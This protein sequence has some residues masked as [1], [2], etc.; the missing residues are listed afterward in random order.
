MRPT[1]RTSSRPRPAPTGRTASTRSSPTSGTAPRATTASPT[2]APAPRRATGPAASPCETC[3]CRGQSSMA[4][5]P[6]C[7]ARRPYRRPHRR[8]LHRR[9]HR[10]RPLRLRG[11]AAPV[12]GGRAAPVRGP[13]ATRTIP[14]VQ[15]ARS[16]ET[17]V[18]I[19]V[20]VR[21]AR[22]ATTAMTIATTM[23]MTRMVPIGGLAMIQ[24]LAAVMVP[25]RSAQVVP[26]AAGVVGAPASARV[27]RIRF[28]SDG[29]LRRRALFSLSFQA[30]TTL[31]SF[32]LA[33][34]FA[35]LSRHL[36]C[37]GLLQRQLCWFARA[38]HVTWVHGNWC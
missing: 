24:V 10:R 20:D 30:M 38:F 3:G 7:V 35:W 4:S 34:L 33:S 25:T 2:A 8:R 27:E 15:A 17:A 23:T 13:A 22:R 19:R 16:V 1:T 5:A 29:D 12:A 6:R 32:S 21:Q 37:R 9:P 36:S 11:A 28:W 14:S 26:S 18:Q 31:A